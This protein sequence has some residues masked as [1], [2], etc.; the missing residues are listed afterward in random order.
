MKNSQESILVENYFSKVTGL[1]SR[2]LFKNRTPPR[3][4]PGNF[5]KYSEQLFLY[6]TCYMVA[7]EFTDNSHSFYPFCPSH[8]YVGTKM[9]EEGWPVQDF[10]LGVVMVNNAL[11][12]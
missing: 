9:N 2:I 8:L 12:K 11:T 4:F 1:H 10:M 5:P 6:Y 7:S 3:V